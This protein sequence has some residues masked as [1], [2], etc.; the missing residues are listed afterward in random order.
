MGK[1]RDTWNP[2]SLR[3]QEA[4]GKTPIFV[5]FDSCMNDNVVCVYV[6]Y[7]THEGCTD[8]TNRINNQVSR[9]DEQKDSD[10]DTTRPGYSKW[11]VTVDDANE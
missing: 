10:D 8:S 9:D 3:A 5:K 4:E 2:E 7:R 11:T 6:L 1:K